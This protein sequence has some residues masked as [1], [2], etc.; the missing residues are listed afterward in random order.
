MND[1][2]FNAK[3]AVEVTQE[4]IFEWYK[5]KDEI[6]RIQARE[7]LLRDKICKSYFPTP[8]EGTNKVQLPDGAEMK[9][10]YKIDRKVDIA[11]FSQIAPQMFERGV[12]VNLLVES[13]PT[14][15]VA[16]YRKLEGETLAI[17]NQCIESKPGSPTL[18]IVPPKA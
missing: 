8:K 13:K 1:F 7:R 14:L 16:N 12:D 5:L 4:E 11:M 15:K 10:T 9:M 17:F 2:D 6:K 3:Q 18:E